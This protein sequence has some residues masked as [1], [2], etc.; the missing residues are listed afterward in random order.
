MLLSGIRISRKLSLPYL[1][2][3]CLKYYLGREQSF[4][5]DFRVQFSI[6]SSVAYK[7]NNV[8]PDRGPNTAR[9]APH[10]A[11]VSVGGMRLLGDH[12]P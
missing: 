3:R 10:P 4:D 11:R 9:V 8:Y 12:S 5:K 1:T 2:K 6:F 7:I